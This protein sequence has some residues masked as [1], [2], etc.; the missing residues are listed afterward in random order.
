MIGLGIPLYKGA[1]NWIWKE[2]L[3][4]NKSSVKLD[5]NGYTLLKLTAKGP[6]IVSQTTIFEQLYELWGI[7]TV[8]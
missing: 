6:W 4:P 8:T 3:E 5:V 7:V 1:P 2:I